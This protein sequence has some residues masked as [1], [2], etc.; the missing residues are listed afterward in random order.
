MLVPRRVRI[1]DALPVD[2]R[3]KLSRAR[4]GELFDGGAR[5][6][7]RRET[8][9]RSE[10]EARARFEVPLSSVRFDGHFV[11]D[12][13][14]PALAQ[15][16]DLVLPTLRES[17]PDLGALT[18]MTRLK[19]TSPIRPG[20]RISVALSRRGER[21]DFALDLSAGTPEAGGSSES[22]G[23]CARGSLHFAA[24]PVTADG[25]ERA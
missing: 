9:E 1:V 19:F 7:V 15:L 25:E 17:W 13:L 4:L 21:V 6:A 2:E 10:N 11:G 8:S 20:S 16:H 14:L 24:R 3:G 12:P 22:G 5:V 23:A 18:R